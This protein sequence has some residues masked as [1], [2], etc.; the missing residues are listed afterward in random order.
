MSLR[1]LSINYKDHNTT[2][3]EDDDDDEEEE[4]EEEEEERKKKRKRKK[5][6][7]RRKKKKEEEEEEEEE[8]ET[9]AHMNISTRF[10]L[11]LSPAL[12]S[13]NLYHQNW[14]DIFYICQHI[15]KYFQNHGK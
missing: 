5:R 8:E 12:M 15:T 9:R 7:R 4:K 3:E 6:R 11:H 13:N 1:R 14:K 10:L 2:E